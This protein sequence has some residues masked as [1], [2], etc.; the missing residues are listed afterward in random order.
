MTD[1]ENLERALGLLEYIQQ[2][3]AVAKAKSASDLQKKID[4]IKEDME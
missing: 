3:L 1:R 4:E 2:V